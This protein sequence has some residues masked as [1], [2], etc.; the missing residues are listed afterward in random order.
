MPAQNRIPINVPFTEKDEAK[1][2]G[3]RWDAQNRT[4]YYTNPA[5]AD[6]FSKWVVQKFMSIDD[7]SDEQ[8][9][10]IEQVKSGKNVL[11]D[12]CIGSGKT[13]AIQVLC[14]E[15]YDKKILYL[16]Y[17]TLLKEDAR[18]KIKQ[19][20]AT[21]TNYHGFAYLCLSKADIPAGVSDL[22]QVFLKIKPK[23]S[24]YD[25]L[26]LDEYQDIEQEIA[27]LLEYIKQSCPNIQIVAVGDMKQKIYDKTT[28]NVP[29]FITGFLG[30]YELMSFTQ[31]FRLSED[32]AARLG[33][34]W[35]KEIKG[36]N[37]NCTI[38]EM[39]MSQVY[40]FLRRQKPSDILC[41][42]ARTGKMSYILNML[43]RQCPDKYNKE[44]VY[45]SISDE[46]RSTTKP[47]KSTA[48]F[49]TFDS[50]KGLERRICVVFD[51]TESY[52]A[53]RA[54]RPLVKYDIVRN[55]FLVAAS[56]GKERII[57]VREG[58]TPLSDKTIAMCSGGVE[59]NLVEAKPLDMAT[60]FSFK[61]KEDVEECY[62][63]IK[64][65]KV[66][67]DDNFI[68]DIASKD[69]LIDLS[70]CIG[71]YQEAAF[72]NNYD[73]DS[74]ILYAQT[75]HED[76]PQ[77]HIPKKATASQKILYLTAFQTCYER[78]VKQ[79]KPDFISEMQK[80]IL[81]DRLKTVF[82]G[83]EDVQVGCRIGFLG[84]AYVECSG[85]CDVIK[86]N[87]VFE[88]KFVS[89]L[90]HEH[91]LQL[92]CYIVAMRMERG[93]IWNTK[94][95]EMYE[96]RIPDRRRF[97]E[98]VVK[99]ITKGAMRRVNI[100]S[101]FLEIDEAYK[102]DPATDTF[103]YERDTKGVEVQPVE[104]PKSV[105]AK[106][107]EI[108]NEPA[109]PK[110]EK[111]SNGGDGYAVFPHISGL[112]LSEIKT[113]DRERFDSKN[114]NR[115]IE[116]SVAAIRSGGK[117]CKLKYDVQELTRIANVL[118]YVN[119]IKE[120][121]AEIYLEAEAPEK[122]VLKAL[123]DSRNS[124]TFLFLKEK[125]NDMYCIIVRLTNQAEG[126]NEFLEFIYAKP[127]ALED[128]RAER[129]TMLG[130]MQSAS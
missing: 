27:E 64:R 98:A 32:F 51:Y 130:L 87:S 35:E 107:A 103:K 111:T 99:T 48:I 56:R 85:R 63:L 28:L 100:P 3:A 47:S 83:E 10:F 73:I 93:F 38:E 18:A 127:M 53:T 122:K 58:D 67:R 90:S 104:A 39:G 69:G 57:F 128:H 37:P 109:P 1:A 115:A 95:N 113:I 43:E 17:N 8:R 54:H 89:E 21:V 125:M 29:T 20:N 88:L 126:S 70:P 123:N 45:A 25:I 46:D 129:D 2:L 4:W 66:K 24:K 9:E 114:Y 117:K 94:N 119:D 120:N 11:V 102:I 96:V 68:I 76:R 52:W 62:K 22:I 124:F 49:T 30:E 81:F 34:I 7:L 59:K 65:I 86:H 97:L 105:E 91:F 118:A 26:V 101:Y 33:K 13:T 79:V 72:F 61:Y 110:M 84:E 71:V 40:E 112:P 80:H 5:D 92:A 36:V 41:L 44:T 31:C 78:Y 42:G 23:I 121:G 12:A 19:P 14:N 15:L 108:V 82:D 6:K 116:Y 77:L 55:I 16:T 60:M 74:E 50:S 75:M 106:P